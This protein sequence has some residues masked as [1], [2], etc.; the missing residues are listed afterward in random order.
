MPNYKFVFIFHT[1]C[2][3]FNLA[4]F[5]LIKYKCIMKYSLWEKKYISLV[6]RRN[7]RKVTESNMTGTPKILSANVWSQHLH[8]QYQH[9]IKKQSIYKTDFD[10]IPI[11]LWFL[12]K[13]SQHYS[14]KIHKVKQGYKQKNMHK[15]NVKKLTLIYK[16][17]NYSE[18]SI[19]LQ[20][21]KRR[22]Q[23]VKDAFSFYI[24]IYLYNF[25]ANI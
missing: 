11:R 15:E 9:D 1:N 21:N 18:S 13:K 7:P 23:G 22:L 20:K 8:V 2:K 12:K 6:N 10:F 25:L 4:P 5:V 17:R 19:A 3:T 16:N 14:P 24:Y